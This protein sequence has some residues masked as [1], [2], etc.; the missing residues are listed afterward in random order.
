MDFSWSD[1]QLKLKESAIRFAKKEL[2][3][4][5]IQRDRNGVFSRELWGKCAEFVIQG[6]PFPE[7]YGE[8]T[9]IF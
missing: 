5:L 6:M 9:R 1:D 2:N 3:D 7:E 8:S 4:Q